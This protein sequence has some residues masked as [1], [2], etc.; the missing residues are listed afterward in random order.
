MADKI[1]IIVGY[2]GSES[3]LTSTEIRDAISSGTIVFL[4]DTEHK[5]MLYPNF[6]DSNNDCYQFE[7]ILGD[8]ILYVT[9]QGDITANPVQTN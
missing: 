9:L 6:F 8:V 3:D 1:K 4:W 5:M 7:D 2:N